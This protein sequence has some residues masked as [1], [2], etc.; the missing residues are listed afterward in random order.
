M[1]TAAL[2]NIS[3]SQQEINTQAVLSLAKFH[4]GNIVFFLLAFFMP[5]KT[6]S[7][8]ALRYILLF[9]LV[10]VSVARYAFQDI[11][12]IAVIPYIPI[13]LG[14]LFASWIFFSRSKK[15]V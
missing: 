2:Q 10:P 7:E 13:A 5:S 1:L 11:M 14:F 6:N 3:V 9:I 8:K 12:P 4:M 15:S